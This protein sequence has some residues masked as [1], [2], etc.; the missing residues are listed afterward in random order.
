MTVYPTTTVRGRPGRRTTLAGAL[1]A[2]VH[3]TASFACAVCFSETNARVLDAYYLTAVLL[4]LLPFVLLGT[5][6]AWL[7]RHYKR[8]AAQSFQA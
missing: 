7:R 6:A 1:V 8:A 5:F 3:P 2:A 4:T